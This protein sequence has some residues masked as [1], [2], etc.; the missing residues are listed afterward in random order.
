MLIRAGQ[1]NVLVRVNLFFLAEVEEAFV[2][3]EGKDGLQDLVK[4]C[5]ELVAEARETRGGK[6]GREQG[7]EG[8]REVGRMSFFLGFLGDNLHFFADVEEAFVEGEG[9][10]GF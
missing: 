1:G 8:A 10:D 3:G 7:R 9:K 2:E 6:G 5:L 4:Q